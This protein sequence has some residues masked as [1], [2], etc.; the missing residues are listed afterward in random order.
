MTHQQPGAEAP[1]KTTDQR[2]RGGKR[3][4]A[5]RKPGYRKPAAKRHQVNVRL[6]TT[7]LAAVERLGNGNASEGLRVLINRAIG[8]S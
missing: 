4:G 7:Q 3:P 5:G 2:T 1:T 6:T 8:N